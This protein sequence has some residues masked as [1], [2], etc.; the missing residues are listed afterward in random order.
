[1][2]LQSADV[3]F[4]PKSTIAELDQFIDQ[5]ITRIVPFQRSFIYTIGKTQNYY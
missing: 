4:L 3:V 5:Y 2:P 1:V